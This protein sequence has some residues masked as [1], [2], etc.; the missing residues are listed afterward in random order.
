MKKVV[1]GIVD[2]PQQAELAVQRLT[3]MGWAPTDVAVL[4]P[5]K[6]GS[7]DFQFERHTHAS[8]GALTGAGLGA[9]LGALAG[10]AIG[11]GVL[12]LP[13]LARLIEAGPI[14]S[15]LACAAAVGVVLAVVGA[16]FGI[17]APKIV[18][19]YYEGK[20][21]KGS[22]LI[23]AHA[24]RR[25]EIRRAREVLRSVAADVTSSDEAAIPHGARA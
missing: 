17:G 6:R 20:V 16:L 9:I 25:D 15:A 2:T 18:A 24:T 13:E 1:L 7:H 12:A 4:F 10:V 19:Q 23:A 22:I 5:D 3:S 14:V 11:L 8:E 21:R